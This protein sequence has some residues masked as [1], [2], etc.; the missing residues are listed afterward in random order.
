MTGP[1]RTEKRI[2]NL[3]ED[4][5]QIEAGIE[6]QV[7]EYRLKLRARLAGKTAAKK[8]ELEVLQRAVAELKAE[9]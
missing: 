3:T 5:S 8:A 1:T 4:L 9:D 2:A 7:G 6:E